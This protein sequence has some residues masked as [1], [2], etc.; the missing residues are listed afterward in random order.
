MRM[1]KNLA[2][3]HERTW[4]SIQA[5]VDP[6]SLQFLSTSSLKVSDQAHL[7]LIILVVSQETCAESPPS[8]KS[9]AG[10]GKIEA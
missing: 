7:I 10:F 8:A 9:H 4:I 3:E 1:N 5:G 2:H 6:K